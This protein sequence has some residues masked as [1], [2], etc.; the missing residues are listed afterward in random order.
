MEIVWL[1]EVS[2]L[3]FP[4]LFGIPVENIRYIHQHHEMIMGPLRP[5]SMKTVEVQSEF[6][7]AKSFPLLPICL[8]GIQ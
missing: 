3:G 2:L 4:R 6:S 7:E 1:H 8:M 5:R